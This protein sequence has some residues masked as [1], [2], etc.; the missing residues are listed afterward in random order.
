MSIQTFLN[1]IRQN[2]T[3]E[4]YPYV[5]PAGD[6]GDTVVCRFFRGGI[7]HP[8]V[9]LKNIGLQF[10]I[11]YENIADGDKVAFDIINH[12]HGLKDVDLSEDV[13]LIN[14]VAVTP[15]PF[16]LGLSEQHRPILIVNLDLYVEDRTS[17]HALCN[18]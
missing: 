15:A 10:M 4:F 6:T 13:R 9:P 16:V 17:A 7:E 18:Q 8:N 14:S 5:F 2:I 11:K 12:F 1:Y 3:A